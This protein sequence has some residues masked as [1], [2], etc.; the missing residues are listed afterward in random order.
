MEE[1]KEKRTLGELIINYSGLVLVGVSFLTFLFLFPSTFTDAATILQLGSQITGISGFS[2]NSALIYSVM[3]ATLLLVVVSIISLFYHNDR[4]SIGFKKEKNRAFFGYL[5]IYILVQLILTEIFAY[6]VP[7][8]GNAFPFQQSVGVQN[9]VFSYLSLEQSIL[10]E[11]IPLSI[12]VIVILAIRGELNLHSLRFH[13][14]ERFEVLILSL[15]IAAV[16]TILITGTYLD[17][18]SDFVS[19]F[20]LNVIFLRFGFFKAFLTN[21]TIAL[22]NV[23]ASLVSPNP[24]LS[25][26]LPVFLFFLGFL[27]IYSLVQVSMS[28]PREEPADEEKRRGNAAEIRRK[29]P[30]IE[31]FIRSRCPNCGNAMYHIILPGLTLKCSKCDLEL[32]R[33]ATGENNIK[34]EMRN[35]ARY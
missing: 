10:Y 18:I 11:F 24:A 35:P 7:N 31:P 12:A 23:T 27:G 5:M 32:E 21:F 3:F 16:A 26:M 28:V 30:T 8:F 6:F 9:F 19:F 15:A 2:V 25:T 1:T 34:I 17:Y 4:I 14:F 29:I 13:E 22:T 20:V 33:D